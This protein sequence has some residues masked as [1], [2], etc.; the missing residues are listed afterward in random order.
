MKTKDTNTAA[1][2][3]NIIRIALATIAILLIP[4]A[5]MQF[6]DEVAWGLEDFVAVGILLFGI[7]LSYELLSRKARSTKQ[8][9]IIGATLL[10]VLL[11]LWAELAVGIFTNWGS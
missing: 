8:R 6:T 1:L 7:G 11:Y 4:F 10:A 3:K 2:N 5:A 9:A